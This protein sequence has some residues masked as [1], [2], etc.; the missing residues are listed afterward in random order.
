MY[1]S[2]EAMRVIHSQ[3][4][5][6]GVD[7]PQNKLSQWNEE[8]RNRQNLMSMNDLRRRAEK[9]ALKRGVY[10]EDMVVYSDG[11]YLSGETV[12]EIEQ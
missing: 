10:R 12:Y 9:D 1:Q 7:I 3:T 11:S 4:D 5:K 6:N 8:W 2:K